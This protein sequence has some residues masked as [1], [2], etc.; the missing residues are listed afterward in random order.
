M[1]HYYMTK[2]LRLSGVPPSDA[3]YY[4]LRIRNTSAF[5]GLYT[6]IGMVIVDLVS[7]DGGD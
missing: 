3:P 6:L 5:F 7:Q 2:R 1:Y 4:V